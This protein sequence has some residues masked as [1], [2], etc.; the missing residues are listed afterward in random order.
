[1]NT[2]LQKECVTY[3]QAKKLQTLGFNDSHCFA[4]YNGDNLN[5]NGGSHKNKHIG[6]INTYVA[7]N[8]I[9]APTYQGAFRWIREKFGFHH[10]ALMNR[11]YIDRGFTF[12]ESESKC[13]NELLK[14]IETEESIQ[15]HI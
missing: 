7:D 11:F 13:L 1:M 10:L 5:L 9:P 8:M 14:K 15:I 12:E 2:L 6:T 4:Y 3:T